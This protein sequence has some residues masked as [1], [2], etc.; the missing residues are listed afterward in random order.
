MKQ[1]RAYKYRFYPTSEQKQIFARTFGCCRYIYNWGL[2]MRTDAYYKHQ[3]RMS[4]DDTSALL[5][6]L[7]KQDD[8]A[9][10]N[11]VP[12]VPLQQSLRHL[13]R[14]FRNFFEGHANYPTFKKRHESQAASCVGTAFQ[15]K[16]QSLTLVKI[17]DPL[18]I[19]WSHPLPD[20]LKPTSVTVTKDC[21]DRYFVSI[22]F[23]EDINSLPV[24]NKQVG[25]D[26]GLKSMVALSTLAK[27]VMSVSTSWK[28]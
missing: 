4:Y 17:D 11:E 28:T 22:Q 1:K 21:A 20:R 24:V 27:P 6:Q 10:L 3:Q 15:L 26:L 14:A 19:H 12:A 23:E 18:D 8:H 2:R 7:K 16:G 13:D 5:T 9:W 25:L